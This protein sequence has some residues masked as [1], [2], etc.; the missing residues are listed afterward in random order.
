MSLIS[1]EEYD[2]EVTASMERNAEYARNSKI[3]DF[4]R[5]KAELGL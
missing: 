3:A 2:R 1:Q 4:H 5:L